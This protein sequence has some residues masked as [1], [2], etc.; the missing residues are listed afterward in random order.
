MVS[1][2]VDGAERPNFVGTDNTGHRS[3]PECGDDVVRFLVCRRR[4]DSVARNQSGRRKV[5][6]WRAAVGCGHELHAWNAIWT[7]SNWLAIDDLTGSDDGN[8]RDWLQRNH[9]G[10]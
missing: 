5:V 6:R 7:Y 8:S 2:P 1:R 10:R 3:W 4:P 9:R